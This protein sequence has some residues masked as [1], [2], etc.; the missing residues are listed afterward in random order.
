MPARSVHPRWHLVLAGVHLG[1]AKPVGRE[2]GSTP[3]GGRGVASRAQRG[4]RG[5]GEGPV[6]R[7]CAAQHS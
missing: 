1:A 2:S 6:W 5:H 7:H 3:R 4:L